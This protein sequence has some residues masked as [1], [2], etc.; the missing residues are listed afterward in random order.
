MKL[1][2]GT[3]VSYNDDTNSYIYDLKKS[4]VKKIT[5]RMFPI[6]LGKNE[7]Q[8]IGYGV[9]DRVGLIDFEQIDAW[10]QIRGT[11]A[12]YFVGKYIQNM[13]Q[14]KLGVELTMKHFTTKS[15]GYDQ[16]GTNKKFGGVIDWGISAPQEYRAVVEVKSKNIKHYDKIIKDKKAPE[17]EVLQGKYLAHL[18]KVDKLLMGYAFFT[19][20]QEKKLQLGVHTLKD[21]QDFD[22]E[23]FIKSVGL[24]F[25]D[26]E[27]GVL[28]FDIDHEEVERD[29]QIAY[30]NLHRIIGLGEI[31][32][33]H[34]KDPEKAELNFLIE[35]DSGVKVYL[36]SELPF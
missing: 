17:E 26:V 13:Y 36:E 6:L 8:G 14:E 22:V 21:T 30:D 27:I 4:R 5:S 29:M 25:E 31:H 23:P 18:S 15:V 24:R 35:E 20:E 10:Y 11:V 34:F 12:E 19:D 3:K 7:Y 32:E 1:K 16:F 2:D 28:R 33:I 9:L